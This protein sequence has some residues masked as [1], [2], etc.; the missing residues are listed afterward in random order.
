MGIFSRTELLIGSEN[1]EK[2]ANA[3]VAV[4]GIGG[5]GGYVAEMLARCGVGRISL[6]DMDTVSETNR[7]RQIIALESTEGMLK[8]EVMKQRILDINPHADVKTYNLFYTKETAESFDLS[9]YDYIADCIDTVS[10]KI[11]LIVRA[12][13]AGTPIISAMGA[14]NKLNPAGFEVAD[15]YKT[16]VCPLA[17]AIRTELRKRG[18]KSLKTVYSREEP[19]KKFT[20]TAGEGL[21]RN[22]PASAAFAPSAMGIVMASEI[23][24]DII[25]L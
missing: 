15:I 18:I 12:K 7:N 1:M 3:N 2:L 14:G 24:K 5:V 9:V 22:I 20:D 6:V 10:S 8:T 21:G 25:S 4:F 23:F 16:S 13:S 19:I 11:E 17:R